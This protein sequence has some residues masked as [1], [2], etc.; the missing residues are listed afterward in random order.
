M[1][2]EIGMSSKTILIYLSTNQLSCRV[3]EYLP[4][5][6][7]FVHN[8]STR[9][10]IYPIC[11]CQSELPFWSIYVSI[12]MS[13]SIKMYSKFDFIAIE[14]HQI[15][16]AALYITLCQS[17]DKINLI[18]NDGNQ[19]FNL[20]HMKTQVFSAFS[21]IS[22]RMGQQDSTLPYKSA[23]RLFFKPWTISCLRAPI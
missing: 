15:M 9:V 19:P 12:I 5:C 4:C 14:T 22:P 20:I 17:L 8:S 2:S 3:F 6:Q 23:T 1:N 13:V 16:S 18:D 7:L 11:I 21:L 10:F